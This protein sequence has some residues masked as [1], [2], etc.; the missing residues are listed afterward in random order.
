[1]GEAA[2]TGREMGP[3]PGS[4]GLW[5]GRPGFTPLEDYYVDGGIA[6]VGAKQ[7]TVT[8]LLVKLYTQ[9]TQ[10]SDGNATA[11]AEIWFRDSSGNRH[12]SGWDNITVYAPL[13]NSGETASSGTFG[14]AYWQTNGTGYWE[15][16]FG[17]DIDNTN[18]SYPVGQSSWY[19][20]SLDIIEVPEELDA[21]GNAFAATH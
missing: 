9:L 10:N 8:H 11:D 20:S 13:L 7:R 17:C 18:N 1:L 21:N 6:V 3:K 12:R 15:G 14:F 2:T 4:Y 19:Q 5:T 16:D